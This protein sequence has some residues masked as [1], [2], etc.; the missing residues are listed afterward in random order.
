MDPL[1]AEIIEAHGGVDRW[2]R[3]EALEAEIS[4]WGLLFTTK[5]VPLLNR[6]RV[7]AQP[8]NL[9]GLMIATQ[10]RVRPLIANMSLPTPTLVAIDIHNVR[11]IVSPD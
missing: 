10:R 5:R 3:L 9:I 4:V 2:Q 6:V 1:L 7:Q 11:P 8:K